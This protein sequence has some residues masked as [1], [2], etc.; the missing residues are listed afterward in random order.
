MTTDLLPLFILLLMLQRYCVDCNAAPST[1]SLNTSQSANSQYP[2]GIAPS[3][4]A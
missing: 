3:P 4:I 2:V 1:V